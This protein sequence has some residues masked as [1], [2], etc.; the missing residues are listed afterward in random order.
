MCIRDRYKAS[1]IGRKNLTEYFRVL[2]FTH[3]GN[4]VYG[5]LTEVTAEFKEMGKPQLSK[6]LSAVYVLSLIHI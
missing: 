6:W 4:T 2:I 5:T 3:R 1:G